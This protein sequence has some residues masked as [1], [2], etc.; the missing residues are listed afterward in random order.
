LGVFPAEIERSALLGP[1]TKIP[2]RPLPD[3]L[4][5]TF[6]QALAFHQSG[7]LA[8]AERAYRAILAEAPEALRS[9][10]HARN[11]ALPDG[12]AS[13]RRGSHSLGDRARG[14]LFCHRPLLIALGDKLARNRLSFPLF[15]TNRF[16]RHIETAYIAMWE[17][18]RSGAPPAAFSVE[19]DG[20]CTVVLDRQ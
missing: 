3:A 11:P 2:E 4:A 14:R 15:D 17:R 9:P 7:N 19:R 12:A 16:R 20:E 10:P 18:Y 8:D 5:D 6:R 1:V 13:G